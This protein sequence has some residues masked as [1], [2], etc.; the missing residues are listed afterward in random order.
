MFFDHMEDLDMSEIM[1][2]TSISQKKKNSFHN[3]ISHCA[4]T[5]GLDGGVSAQG[6]P[7][8]GARVPSLGA[9]IIQVIASALRP[10][11]PIRAHGLKSL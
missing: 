1:H 10:V 8:W 4:G 3:T 6:R 5:L 11:V 2:R 9:Y 7:A